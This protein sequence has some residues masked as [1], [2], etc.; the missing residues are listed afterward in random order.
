MAKTAK[1]KYDCPECHNPDR[2]TRKGL[3]KPY[4][5]GFYRMMCHTCRTT[6]TRFIPEA[7]GL[8]SN[9]PP[10]L[11]PEPAPVNQGEAHPQAKLN[12]RQVRDIVSLYDSG[13]D[14]EELAD[15]FGVAKATIAM[16]LS[17]ETWAHLTCIQPNNPKPPRSRKL[18][19]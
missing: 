12:E 17:G 15:R 3:Y 6:F 19:R 11:L 16:I 14:A 13:S 18:S 8:P 7:I 2:V 1:Y 5:P 10:P 9:S 4:G